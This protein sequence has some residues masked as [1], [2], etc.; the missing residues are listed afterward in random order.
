MWIVLQVVIIIFGPWL[1]LLGLRKLSFAEWLSPVVLSYLLGILLITFSIFPLDDHISEIAGDASILLAI[2]LLL[3][4]T[5]IKKWFSHA[6]NTVL[7]FGL[8]IIAGS[9]SAIFYA[10]LLQQ[11]IPDVS[12]IAGMLAGV[13]TGGTPNMQAIGLAL[14]VPEETF[15]LLNATDLFWSGIYL[16]FL[17]TIGSR[18]LARFLPAYQ[19]NQVDIDATQELADTK[20]NK[21]SISSLFQSL[22]MAVAIVGLSLGTTF[23]IFNK[24]APVAFIILMLTTLS[25][26]AS[27][28]PR[29]RSLVASYSAGEY[30]LLVFCIAIGMRSDFRE[31]LEQGGIT[32]LFT[33]LVINTCIVL[34]YFLAWLFKI[35]RDTTMITS[36]AAIF[37]PAFIGQIASS[38]GNRE[39]VF[40][41]MATGLVGYAVGN[42]LGVGVAYLLSWWI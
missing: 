19:S 10:L 16:I 33:G 7:S 34:H 36:T 1:I 41:G 38:L 29:V 4:S 26:A 32:I 2:P 15:V 8:C 18:L 40:A 23:L 35:D 6:G 37:G 24:L 3:F 14:E 9:V 28:L 30:L 21:F 31:L 12:S 39:I 42:Y 22:G 27:F 20:K 11:S 5:N 25:V 13:Y 17:T